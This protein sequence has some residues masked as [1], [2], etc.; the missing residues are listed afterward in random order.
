MARILVIDDDAHLLS[1]IEQALSVRGHSVVTATDG[2][3]G[4]RLFRAEPFNL[5]ITDIVMPEREGLETIM[6]LRREFPH[7][8]VIAM[9][10]MGVHSKLYL[11]IATRLGA[12][13]VLE[14]P[15]SLALLTGAVES[16]LEGGPQ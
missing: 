15:F 8:P 12:R 1:T 2:I 4:E 11:G 16:L 9:T 3:Q 10:G 6:V 7:V 13:R 5:I 14:K